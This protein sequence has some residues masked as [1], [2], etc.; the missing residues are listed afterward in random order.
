MYEFGFILDRL[1]CKCVRVVG[2]VFGKY[3]F[4]GD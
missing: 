1:F 3:Y 4:Y 2:D